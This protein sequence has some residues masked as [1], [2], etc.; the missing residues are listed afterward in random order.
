[1][2]RTEYTRINSK[3]FP[4]Y[5]REKYHIDGLIEAD[6]YLYI[7]IIKGMYGLKQAAR[8]A[9]NHLI[10]CMEP[11]G[12][13]PVPFITVL[14]AHKT[15]KIKYCLCVDDFGV[16]VFT[17]YDVNH[18]INSLKKHYAI[19]TYWEGNNYLGLKID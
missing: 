7:K 14:W 3:Y 16:N 4:I 10:S 1:M 6:G 17:K 12:Y 9:Y 18:L 19:S 11:R 13:Y 5:I 8:I 2:S 15:R